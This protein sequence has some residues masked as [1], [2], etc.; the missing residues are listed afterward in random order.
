MG[1]CSSAIFVVNQAAFNINLQKYKRQRT[2]ETRNDTKPI[3]KLLKWIRNVSGRKNGPGTCQECPKT[4]G[5]APGPF[6]ARRRIET[7]GTTGSSPENH[8]RE[9]PGGKRGGKNTKERAKER[10]RKEEKHPHRETRGTHTRERR[11]SHK[12]PALT[13]LQGERGGFR[14][15]IDSSTAFSDFYSNC[16]FCCKKTLRINFS[17]P[18]PRILSRIPFRKF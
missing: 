18:I 8:F 12:T 10:R 14:V 9:V 16:S 17:N 4:R 1:I 7:P 6:L 2:E 15:Q 3:S 13:N 5:I 11:K